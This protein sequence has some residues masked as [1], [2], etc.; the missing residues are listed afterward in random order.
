MLLLILRRIASFIPVLFGLSV[1]VFVW[2][3]V[4]PGGPAVAQL[5]QEATP[6]NIAAANKL[7][8]FDQPLVVQYADFLDRMVHLDFGA[9]T[10]TDLPAVDELASRFPATLELTLA[11]LA[12]A[13]VF[14]LPLGYFAA[15]HPGTWL[16]RGVLATSLVGYVVPVFVTGFVL[17][18]IF[19]VWLGWLPTTGRQS[20]DIL[21][22]HPTGLYV[23]DGILTGNLA[24]AVD[25]VRHLILPGITLGSITYGAVV[26]ITRAAVTRVLGQDYIRTAEA[27]GLPAGLIARRHIM[28]N[29]AP[30]ITTII[31]VHVGLLLSGAV[32][33][34]T[35]FGIPGMGSFMASAI[36]A[37]DYATIEVFILFAAVLVASASLL[38]DISYAFFDPRVRIT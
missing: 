12:F 23:L 34:E 9:S 22:A 19:G 2:I 35:V 6:A 30:S 17:K 31:G 37:R 1:A 29:A 26:R 7:Y 21:A 18:L 10:Q 8:G 4:L 33:T 20:A 25:A 15:R 11:A 28:R 5:G 16:D 24:A 27:K 36:F 38:V 14:G 13:L 3:H 32:L